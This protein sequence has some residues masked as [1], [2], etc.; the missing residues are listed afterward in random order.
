MDIKNINKSHF[1]HYGFTLIELL[2]TIGIL[3]IL[4]SIAIPGF[5]R[6]VPNY[7]LRG[8]T[9][10]LISAVQVARFSAIKEHAKVVILFHIGTNS[11]EA[12]VDNGAGGGTA[13]NWIRDGAESYIVDPNQN[14]GFIPNRVTMYAASF[15]GGAARVRFS[16]RGFPNGMGGHVYMINSQNR[17]M[18]FILNLAGNLRIITSTDGTTWN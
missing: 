17:Y 8:A 3:G 1:S 14:G 5:S 15:A 11:Y 6:W 4:A 18:G 7:R 2:V 16:P 10:D 12:F 13:D 9:R